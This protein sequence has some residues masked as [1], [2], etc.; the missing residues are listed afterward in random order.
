MRALSRAARLLPPSAGTAA[1]A[2]SVA[3][4]AALSPAAP[5]ADAVMEDEY[6]EMDDSGK[7]FHLPRFTTESG[8]TLHDVQLRYRTW[9]EMNEEKDNVL[10][11]CHAL[12][13]NAALDDWWSSFLGD[14]LPF[15]TSKYYVICANLLGSCYGSTGPSSINPA[16]G[17]PYGP[18]FPRLTVRDGVAVQKQM[19]RWGEGVKQVKCVIGGSLGG[20]QTVEWLFNDHYYTARRTVWVSLKIAYGGLIRTTTARSPSCALLFRWRV[21]RIITRGRLPSPRRSASAFTPTP[22]SRAAGT[23]IPGAAQRRA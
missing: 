9:G 23:T 13:G 12:T 8:E 10:V 11:V 22:I 7:T 17:L 2:R 20:M 16:T 15:D 1:P 19:V 18:D 4:R 3:T 6:G 5:D 21:A 14:G